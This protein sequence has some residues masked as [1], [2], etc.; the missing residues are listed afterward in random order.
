MSEKLLDVVRLKAACDKAVTEPA[1]QPHKTEWG[2]LE[3]HCNQA[4]VEIAGEMGIEIPLL[5]ANELC[6]LFA[7]KWE[8]VSPGNAVQ[9][10][11]LGGIAVAAKKFTDHGHVAIIYPVQMQHSETYCQ[12]V[13]V[14]AN[15]GKENRVMRVS[16][17]FK[18][19]DAPDYFAAPRAA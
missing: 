4:V 18:H 14:V 19:C 15:V 7:E 6:D 17:A 10:A 8:K 12:N 1:F 5:L 13:P 16:E 11:M 2:T 9:I 3:T